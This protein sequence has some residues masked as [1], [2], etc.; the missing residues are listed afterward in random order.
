MIRNGRVCHANCTECWAHEIQALF[1]NSE[2]VKF[3]AIFEILNEMLDGLPIDYDK[4]TSSPP[5]PRLE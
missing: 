5:A 1:D 3:H 4:L 2:F